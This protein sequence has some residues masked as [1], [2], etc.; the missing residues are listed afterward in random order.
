MKFKQIVS[1]LSLSALTFLVSCKPKDA[2]LQKAATEI[3]V[4]AP[5]INVAV[6]DGVA[7]LTGNVS[8]A[9]IAAAAAEATGKIKGITSVTNNVMV[10]PQPIP[11]AEVV[12][13]SPDETLKTAVNDVAKDFPSVTTTV[14]DGVIA[15]KG[16]LSAS[17]W[18]TLKMALDGLQ[19]KKVDASGLTIK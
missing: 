3:L 16:E 12:S 15:V 6:K 2:D 18:K 4:I 1:V 19:P 7:T 11:P 17:K 13:I 10:N 9:A 8:D 14:A 5:G